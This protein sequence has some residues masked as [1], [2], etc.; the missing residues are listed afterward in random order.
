MTQRTESQYAA[1]NEVYA[2]E[3][4][5]NENC[6]VFFLLR[7]CIKLSAPPTPLHLLPYLNPL[8]EV[9]LHVYGEGVGRGVSFI[10]TAV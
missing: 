10:E 4:E 7:V 3:D 2:N 5:V 6:D 8:M 9:Y 1:S